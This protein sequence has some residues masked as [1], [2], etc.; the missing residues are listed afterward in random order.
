MVARG[1]HVLVRL[2]LQQSVGLGKR[3]LV[4]GRVVG[5]VGQE[6]LDHRQSLRDEIDAV[7]LLLPQL[8]IVGR[9]RG[10]GINPL[11]ES[12]RRGRDIRLRRILRE[13]PI[14]EGHAADEF[15][16]PLEEAG[17]GRLAEKAAFGRR[18][19]DEIAP[20][21]FTHLVIGGRHLDDLLERELQL[22]PFLLDDLEVAHDLGRRAGLEM[23]VQQHAGGFL[24]GLGVHVP[25]AE[26]LAEIRAG[27]FE[28][29]LVEL[30]LAEFEQLLRREAVGI[31]ALRAESKHGQLLGLR[32]GHL[33]RSIG[34]ADHGRGRPIVAGQIAVDVEADRIDV[35]PAADVER[36]A[37]RIDLVPL[38]AAGDRILDHRHSA[39][40]RLGDDEIFDL[41]LRRVRRDVAPP[42]LQLDV[43]AAADR[44]LR[45]RIAERGEAPLQVGE[46][47][48]DFLAIEFQRGRFV[49]P[50]DA[51]ILSRAF[52]FVRFDEAGEDRLER[53]L[54]SARELEVHPLLAGLEHA[55]RNI[56]DKAAGLFVDVERFD[57]QIVDDD[58]QLVMLFVETRAAEPAGGGERGRAS[59]L[60]GRPAMARAMRHEP[61]DQVLGFRAVGRGFFK[62]QSVKGADFD[63]RLA[64]RKTAQAGRA[65]G[66]LV[67]IPLAKQC[68]QVLGHRLVVHLGQ[69]PARDSRAPRSKVQAD[70]DTA[71]W[72]A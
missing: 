41:L 54:P 25:F 15:A 5:K 8:G 53:V 13:Q 69:E 22:G 32:R 12:E 34:V 62:R 52:Q 17:H 63:A 59:R 42:N 38:E 44:Q 39:G 65:A 50:P 1:D 26:Q 72:R 28:I 49:M 37:A 43:P 71:D 18:A 23:D 21:V 61:V 24:V 20:L 47:A 57:F 48:G 36:D 27:L 56:D 46:A 10:L 14:H 70:C 60:V 35:G 40:Q 19:K 64:P 16:L 31:G 51:P 4:G 30:S 58:R 6:V 7:D 55:R 29:F 45:Q 11:R 68:E 3:G 9:L 33:I 66:N 67:E 2:Q